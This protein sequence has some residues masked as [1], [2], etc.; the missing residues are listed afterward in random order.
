MGYWTADD[1]PFINSLAETFPVADRWFSSCLGP[2]LPNRRFLVAG[3]GAAHDYPPRGTIFDLLTANGISWVN[4]QDNATPRELA[5]SHAFGLRGL[6]LG[7]RIGGVLRA[8]SPIVLPPTLGLPRFTADIFPVSTA[9]LLGHVR[10]L[11]DFFAD[12]LSGNLPS[13]SVV[14]PGFRTNSGQPPQDVRAA[15]DFTAAVV[16]SLMGGKGWPHTLFIWV[17][18][19]WGGYYDHVPPPEAVPPEEVSASGPPDPAND[20]SRYGFR[21]PAVIVSP[22]ARPYFVLHDVLDHTSVLKL[23][24]EKWNLPPLTRRDAAAMSPMGA[25]DLDVP[26]AFLIP[27]QLAAPGLSPLAARELRP[28]FRIDV[29][30][31]FNVTS[32][33]NLARGLF[34]IAAAWAVG[35]IAFGGSNFWFQAI[36]L[37]ACTG[38]AIQGVLGTAF[39]RQWIF[40]RP[41]RY[42]GM[43]A[44][45]HAV[46]AFFTLSASCALLS[47]ELYRLGVFRLAEVRL[48]GNVLW[49]HTANYFWNLV[50]GIP[51]LQI[52]GT[53]HWDS[54]LHFSNIWGELFI[55]LFRLMVLGPL[56]SVIAQ[57]LQ[58]GGRE[59]K[60]PAGNPVPPL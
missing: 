23:I 16:N 54:P 48:S 35:L 42:S 55:I 59:A 20:H 47:S 24:E 15:E 1:L 43:N 4:Y 28:P 38:L 57:A 13:V 56:L 9:R 10:P 22:F 51:G 18:D 2:S 46:F 3:T 26:P 32:L 25:L 52:T 53:L 58:E 12:A 36:V 37:L 11:G 8:V 14:D 17:H 19:S 45:Y 30:P 34:W 21:V 7:R 5:I 39:W 60:N 6:K 50:D 41:P 27:P 33:P 49:I 29:S 44:V 40:W 31:L